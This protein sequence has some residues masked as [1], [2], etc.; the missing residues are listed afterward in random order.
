MVGVD[1]S[2]SMERYRVHL[3]V[4]EGPLD[5]LLRLIE[6]EELDITRVSLAR[7]ADG[8]LLHLDQ[9]RQRSAA[10]LAEFLVIAAR[11]LV[12]KSR[13][14]LPRSDDESE[15]EEDWETDLVERL[16]EYKRYRAA[17]GHLREIEESGRRSY[18]RVAPPPRLKARLD[19][20]SASPG[21]LLQALL[22]ALAAHK[23]PSP[24]DGVVAPITVHIRDCMARILSRV[25]ARRRVSF[26]ELMAAS[27]SR[28]EIIVMFLGLLELIK[29]QRVRAYQDALF[30]EI[31]IQAREPD[32]NVAIDAD[33]LE[34]YG[35]A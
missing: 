19:P 15:D 24:V 28:M 17:A 27:R 11:L 2:V 25:A 13:V 29:Q 8:Y 35:E 18:P 32:P 21:E 20:G 26:R 31:G 7:V 6:R 14:L 9:V 4:Y 33:D 1:G 23:V 16:R 5:L 3:E 34:E 10:N 22:R 30:G 12:L